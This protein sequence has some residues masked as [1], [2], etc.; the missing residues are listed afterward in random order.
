MPRTLYL[1]A[2]GGRVRYV[3]R[4]G[5]G[6][7]TT[8]RKFV[9]AHMHEKASALGRDRPARVQESMTATRHG[10]EPRIKPR[11]KIELEFIEAI[12][13]DLREDETVGDFDNLVIAAPAKLL[14]ALRKS[15]PA[16]F[17]AK[18]VDSIDKDLTKIPD[19]DLY[20]HLPVFLASKAAS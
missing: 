3:E 12:A 6:H 16:A 13:A 19:S 4:T 14:K 7:F 18:L 8:F 17:T 2:D 11:D 20:R 5:P 9:S 10:I 1:I 15:L